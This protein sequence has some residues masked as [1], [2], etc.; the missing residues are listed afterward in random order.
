MDSQHVLIVI[1]SFVEQLVK[2][3][4]V[5]LIVLQQLLMS[6]LQKLMLMDHVKY[7]ITIKKMN[8]QLVTQS[9]QLLVL[10]LTQTKLLVN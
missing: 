7:V 3:P 10:I 5:Q 4:N 2:I 6:V 1:V 9:V 8:V